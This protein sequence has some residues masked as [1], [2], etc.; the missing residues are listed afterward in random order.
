MYEWTTGAGSLDTRRLLRA[1]D[2]W[3]YFLHRLARFSYFQVGNFQEPGL[4]ADPGLGSARPRLKL[5]VISWS[6]LQFRLA[7][8]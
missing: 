5:A 1:A 8:L 3:T 6:A 4:V 2:F 7:L